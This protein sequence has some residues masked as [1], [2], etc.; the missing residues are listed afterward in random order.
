MSGKLL[1][2]GMLDGF[3]ENIELGHFGTRRLR[4]LPANTELGT[5]WFQLSKEYAGQLLC[6]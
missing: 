1:S 4:L 6:L 5:L 3:C 2:A